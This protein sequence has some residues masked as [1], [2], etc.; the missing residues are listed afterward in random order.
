M[1]VTN[2]GAVAMMEALSPLLARTDEVGYAAAYNSRKL[3]ELSQEY[4][5]LHER[6]LAEYGEPV[7]GDDGR[8]VPGEYVIRPG[9]PEYESFVADVGCWAAAEHDFEPY[10]VAARDVAGTM[11]GADMLALA[12]MIDWDRR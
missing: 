8:E 1:R 6:K 2:D 7:V 5:K 9:T 3:T 11:S 12:W 4:I 10:R